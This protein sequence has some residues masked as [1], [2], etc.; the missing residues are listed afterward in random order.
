MDVEVVT[1]T[2]ADKH[3]VKNLY[4][5]YFY[6]VSEYHSATS[7]LAG[8]DRSNVN[9][10][11]V[12]G[13]PEFRSHDDTVRWLDDYWEVRDRFP[14]LIRTDGH[15]LGLAVVFAPQGAVRA[16]YADVDFYMDD[17]FILRRYRRQGVGRAAAFQIFDRL[18]GTWGVGQAPSNPGSVLFWQRTIG[19]YTGGRFENLNNGAFQ[20]FTNGVE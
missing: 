18:R 6:D 7:G 9:A 10:H 17:F 13:P 2:L 8:V 3:V 16:E 20:R 5:Y 4:A 19:D 1:S 15:W 11:G 14:F 12:Y